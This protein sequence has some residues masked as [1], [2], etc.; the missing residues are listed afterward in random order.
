MVIVLMMLLLIG[1]AALVFWNIL[2]LWAKSEHEMEAAHYAYRT[3]TEKYVQLQEKYNA[4]AAALEALDGFA[5]SWRKMNHDP[6]SSEKKMAKLQKTISKLDSGNFSGVN[7]LVLPGYAL[8]KMLNITGDKKAFQN[9]V[10]MYSNLKGREYAINNTRYLFASMFSCAIGGVGFTIV[11]G[12]LLFASGNNEGIGLMMAIGGPLL[13]LLMAFALYEDVKSKAK[14]RKEAIMKDFAQVVTEIALLTSSGME[15]FRAWREVCQSPMRTGPL[16]MEM[17]QTIGEIDSGFQPSAAL[18]G[19]IK[20]CGTKDT[21]RLGASILQNLTR[22]NDELSRFLEEL[23]GD[24]WEERKHAARRLGEQ[25]K[26]KLVAPMGLIFLGIL[27]IIGVAV[28]SGMS[29]LGF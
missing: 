16:F 17:R 25:A 6:K 5:R 2:M 1:T 29:G 11:L 8:I 27:I 10:T 23:S 28:A 19:F 21:S 14:K 24:V 18:E 22:G 26:S 4:D 15:M 20:R 12:T 3:A 7:F 9:A 13:S